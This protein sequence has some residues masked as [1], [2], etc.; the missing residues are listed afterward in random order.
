[1]TA[2]SFLSELGTRLFQ[3]GDICSRFLLRSSPSDQPVVTGSKIPGKEDLTID[4][5]EKS[6]EPICT[7]CSMSAMLS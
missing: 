2:P 6:K 7:V 3:K 4:L 1:M 5:E